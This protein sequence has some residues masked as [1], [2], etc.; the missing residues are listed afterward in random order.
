MNMGSV[1]MKFRKII[2][3]ISLTLFMLT[4]TLMPLMVGAHTIES[5]FTVPLVK[6]HN[7]IPIGF[8]KVWNDADNL[9][10]L[11]EID[12][13]SYPNYAMEESHLHVSTS[14]LS[15]FAPGLWLYHHTYSPPKTYDLYT[16]PLSSIDGGVSGGT[17]IYL[18]AHAS[19]CKF[20]FRCRCCWHIGSAYG[21]KFKGSFNY[22]IQGAPPAE[23]EL[24]IIKTGPSLAYPG[25]TYTYTITVSNVGNT[26]AYNVNVTDKLPNGVLPA[27]PESPGTPTGV[28]DEAKNMVNWTIG[29]LHANG[30]VVITLEVWFN[31][32]LTP[33]EILTN[34]VQ[35]VWEDEG[36]SVYGPKTATW[37]T[38]IIAGP[39]LSIE[40]IGPIISYPGDILV[41]SMI[42]SNIGNAT[43]YNI[44]VEDTFPSTY[45]EYVSS[46]PAGTLSGN[47]VTWNLGSLSENGSILITLT[48]RVRD[49]VANGTQIVDHVEVTWEDNAG[50]SYGPETDEFVTVIFSNPLLDITKTGPLNAYPDQTIEYT[51][52]VTN[53]GGSNASDVV[54]T[55]TLP[56]GTTYISASPTP[57][58][59]N[60]IL[61][62]SLGEI[63][64]EETVT[65]TVCVKVT[66]HPDKCTCI[67]NNATVIW[68]D[69]LDRSYGPAWDVMTTR[70][71][72]EPLLEVNKTGDIKGMIGETLN[73]NITITNVGGSEAA[74]IHIID[75]LPYNLTLLTSSI[76]YD[77]YDPSTGRIIWNLANPI[78]SDETVQISLTVN[79]TDVEYDGILVFN[80]VYVN[81]TD[82]PGENAYGPVT[83]IHPVQLFI[84]PYAKVSKY[85][86]LEA[87][88]N[89]TITYTIELYNPTESTLTEVTLTDY[90]PDGVIYKN[91]SPTGTYNS[92][93]HTVTWTSI[94]L[95]PGQAINFTIEV[96]VH[97]HV[98]AGALIVDET[99]ASWRTGSDLDILITEILE[100][101]SR[102]V[103]GK[104]VDNYGIQFYTVIMAIVITAA[105][106]GLLTKMRKYRLLEEDYF[107]R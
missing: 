105:A 7:N 72:S 82:S 57:T 101:P 84:R 5:P 67:T 28:Y 76:P 42:V 64:P 62:W 86:P 3:S 36:G 68:K 61:N 4:L 47:K 52:S 56:T 17:V 29:D 90:L 6:G 95:A 18:M 13:G 58:V 102:P 39:K 74:N 12:T 60:Q 26:T 50:G 11:F 106:I 19:I 49:S 85:G 69:E 65:L 66:V 75:D 25:G 89:S 98:P 32:T 54:V 77:S 107:T 99:I 87:Y 1:D 41:Y 55:D 27:Y 70:I 51:I 97:L 37:N 81:W 34:T 21:F 15:W 88:K 23:P 40:K 43:A 31:D 100:Q 104:I 92:A 79:V 22:T 103:G 10:V 93:S 80:N 30:I 33:G 78:G 9:Y 59:H 46:T 53:L 24:S 96:Y 2:L 48:V 14:P 45:L 20:K 91:S 63:M 44:R 16:I 8:I 73:F 83:D 35:T 71:C 94:T 38:T